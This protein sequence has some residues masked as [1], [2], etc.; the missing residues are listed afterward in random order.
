[1]MN[2][3][4]VNIMLFLGAIIVAVVIYSMCFTPKNK[5]GMMTAPTFEQPLKSGFR[6]NNYLQIPIKVSYH[7]KLLE[8]RVSDINIEPE[9]YKLIGWNIITPRKGGQ[10]SFEGYLNKNKMPVRILKDYVITNS[11]QKEL[12]VGMVNTRQLFFESSVFKG[13]VY[14]I[15]KIRIHNRGKFPLHFNGHIL[16]DPGCVYT[17]SGIGDMPAGVPT[18]TILRNN[19]GIYGDFKIMRPITDIYYGLIS[20]YKVPLYSGKSYL[21]PGDLE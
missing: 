11:Q 2:S 20:E 19:E 18:G 10:F 4:G 12:N 9:S 8:K 1:M 21:E 6:I 13:T 16:V 14:E 5:E 15:P 7:D 17:Y 3:D